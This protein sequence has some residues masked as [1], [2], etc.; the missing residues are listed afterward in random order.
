MFNC[1]IW[2]RTLGVKSEI[3]RFAYIGPY[4]A[5]FSVIC[6]YVQGT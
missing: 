2:P 5:Q 1:E 3:S 6:M 4:Q